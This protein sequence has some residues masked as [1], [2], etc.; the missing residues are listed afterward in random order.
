MFSI[1]T[2]IILSSYFKKA[3]SSRTK[4]YLVK[5]VILEIGLLSAG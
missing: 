3:A 2:R 4:I 1:E 5:K